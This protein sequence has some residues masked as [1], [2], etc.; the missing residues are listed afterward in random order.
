M[1]GGLQR[2]QAACV[3]WGA[4]CIAIEWRGPRKL[5][6]LMDEPALDWDVSMGSS[7]LFAAMNLVAPLIPERLYRRPLMLG[8]FARA[9]RRWFGMGDIDLLGTVPNGQLGILLPGG[10]SRSSPRARCSAA[11]TS[12]S[13]CA[14][15]RIPPSEPCV[16]PPAR[17]SPWARGT[18]PLCSDDAC[19]LARSEAPLPQSRAFRPLARLRGAIGPSWRYAPCQT[20]VASLNPVFRSKFRGPGLA[21]GRPSHFRLFEMPAGGYFSAAFLLGSSD[22]FTY[23]MPQGPTPCSWMMVWP[24]AIP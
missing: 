2:E 9:A 5:R 13:R 6:V 24:F 8:L 14:R 21:P 17:C 20:K 4:W 7:L 18:S 23:V 19:Y 11:R 3:P 1:E 12:A 15:G 22:G 16:C 10:C